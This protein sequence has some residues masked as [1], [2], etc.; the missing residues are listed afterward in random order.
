MS[1]TSV[2]RAIKP[3]T[4]EDTAKC[5]A[6]ILAVPIHAFEEVLAKIVP[7]A[8]KDTVIVDIATVKVHTAGLLKK[9]AK[10]HRYLA[11]HPM[12][13]PESYEKRA[14]DVK[15]FRIVMTDGTLAVP[16]YVALT[17]FLKKLGFDV[18][19]MKSEAHDKQIA[20]TLFLTHL[21][22]QTVLEGGFGRTDID[23]VSFGYL[24]DA[25]ESVRRDEKLF[26]DVFLFN[27]YCQDVLT[28]F[29]QAEEKVRG[30]LGK[31]NEV[32]TKDGIKIGISGA[33]GSFSQEA[34]EK[35]IED[36]KIK[37]STLV[38]LISVENV[39]SALEAGSIDLGVFPIENSTGGVVTETVH[40]MAKHNFN[41]KK[42][43]D[44][45]IHQN[46]MVQEGVKEGEIKT[47]T[48]H[49]QAL[50]QCREYL[51]KKWPKAKI[52]EYEDTAR[53]AEDLA[54]GKLPG[55]TAVIASATAA[56]LYK[57]EILGESIQDL[58]TNYTTF[59][60]ASS[61]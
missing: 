29:K 60:V 32:L 55:T 23:T 49:E 5:D 4:H 17:E 10:G 9:L 6:V 27:P 40:A 25:V 48:S 11:T 26:Q 8:G 30:S 24:M 22:G 7:L 59:I 54:T 21:I 28:R 58:K 45:D 37:N 44:I 41:I 35:Y 15:G 18:V 53:A 43:F 46:L 34:A 13:G 50:K 31:Q 39:L 52:E 2:T 16:E 12:W 20:E 19:E 51:L 42:I 61:R 38:Y 56:K 33:Q 57:L 3:Y 1:C 36:S 14:G 47:I